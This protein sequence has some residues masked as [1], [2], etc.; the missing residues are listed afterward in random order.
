MTTF[1]AAAKSA[2]LGQVA[3]LKAD[4]ARIETMVNGL[5]VVV[6]VPPPSPPVI[7]PIPPAPGAIAIAPPSAPVF[8]G[9][10]TGQSD[11]SAAL[12]AFLQ[13]G[14]QRALKP[15]GVYRADQRIQTTLSGLDLF[16]QGATVHSQ[17]LYAPN[18]PDSWLRLVKCQNVH[19]RDF[20]LIGPAAADVAATA[21]KLYGWSREDWRGL[22]IDGGKGIT[23][24]RVKSSRFYGDSLYIA[25]RDGPV[26][27][28][29]TPDGVTLI[30]CD[31]RQAGRNAVSLT[32]GRNVTVTGGYIGDGG[33]A[34]WDTE[35]NLVT[36][37]TS[38][39]HFTGTRFG[40]GDVGKTVSASHDSKV[41]ANGYAVYVSAGAAPARDYSFD[42]CQ[43][44]VG[45]LYVVA[46]GG[47][48]ANI[49]IR[50]CV[51]TKAGDAR[52]AGTDGIVFS[53]NTGI[54]RVGQ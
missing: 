11:V 3:L 42:R 46:N 15:G 28:L 6:P 53:G 48:N 30:D 17:G 12:S 54:A 40:P 8:T 19:L 13:A 49:A 27:A 34:A 2:L 22:I 23:L 41:P 24:E 37:I 26:D 47:R 14:G 32:A 31:F 7:V 1:D 20:D 36:D 39:V 52:F 45:S 9:D 43:F 44:D 38:G 51:A 4:A 33:L 29:S 35:P 50:D 25:R 16:G 21:W 10:A 5:D 18:L